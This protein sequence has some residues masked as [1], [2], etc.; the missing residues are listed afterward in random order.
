MIIT[1]KI[2]WFHLPKTAG[3]TTEKLFKC[4]GIP[5]LWND[6]QS[7]PLKHLPLSEHPS[8]NE[9]PPV[10]QHQFVVNFRRLPF[11]LLSNMQHKKIMMNLSIDSSPMSSGMFWRDRDQAWLPADWWLER[12]GVDQ[13][14][15]LLRVDHL[16]YDFLRFVQLYEPLSF[17]SRLRVRFA[18]SLNRNNYERKLSNS[19]SSSD[20]KCM[21]A[22]NP[23][24]AELEIRAYGNLLSLS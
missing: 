9:L 20:I 22:A 10:S 6:D 19:F 5:L 8:K 23:L 12:F 7:S 3:T 17:R 13:E 24:W 21:Y 2:S 4:S 14:W 18:S 11:W 16:K 1:N 15:T